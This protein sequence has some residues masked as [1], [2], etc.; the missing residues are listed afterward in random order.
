MRRLF[1]KI[2]RFA[3]I[4][5][6]IGFLRSPN[7]ETIIEDIYSQKNKPSNRSRIFFDLLEKLASDKYFRTLFYFRTRGFLSNFLRIFF[8]RDQRFTIDINTELGG[9]VILAH[10]YSSI[11][12]AESVGKNLYIN[13]LVTIGENNGHRPKIGNNVKLYTNATIIGGITI[14]DNVVVGAGSVVVK[15]V[16]SNCIIAGNPAKIIRY[17]K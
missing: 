17:V 8:P 13:Q 14:G 4:L 7:K 2:Y 16:P 1:I 11:I 10:P 15:D 3:F 5:H 6:G 12:N 9:G